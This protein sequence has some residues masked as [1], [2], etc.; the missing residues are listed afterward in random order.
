VTETRPWSVVAGGLV[1]AVRL[2]PRGGRDAIE[3]VEQRADGQCVLK[4]RVRA[5][6]R[7]GEANDALVALL[8]RVAHV[9][10]RNVTLVSGTTARIKRLMIAGNGPTI[11]ATLEQAASGG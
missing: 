6:P 7:E 4:A 11:A 5:A 1:V 2:T 10:P 9:P 3:G 8:A